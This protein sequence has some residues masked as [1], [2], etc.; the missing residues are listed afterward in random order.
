MMFILKHHSLQLFNLKVA[1][2]YYLLIFKNYYYVI[3][4]TLCSFK[5]VTKLIWMMIGIFFTKS[6]EN[7]IKLNLYQKF[8][9]M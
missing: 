2:L 3:K 9:N 8:S 7:T 4:F 5:T 1:T 6:F